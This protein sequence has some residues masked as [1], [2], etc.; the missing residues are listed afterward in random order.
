MTIENCLDKH[1]TY[2]LTDP[3]SC[4][5]DFYRAGPDGAPSFIGSISKVYHW[6]TDFLGVYVDGVAASRPGCFAYAD[7][8]SI[9]APIVGSSM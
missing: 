2:L 3:A 7:M 8:L 1:P 5:F 9:G 4:P 6:L